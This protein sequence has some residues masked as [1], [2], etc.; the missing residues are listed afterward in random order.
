M[1][2]KKNNSGFTLIEVVAVIGVL[3]VTSA[4][5]IAN[6][7]LNELQLSLSKDSALIASTVSKAKSLALQNSAETAGYG[8]RFNPE[9]VG[10]DSFFIFKDNSNNGYTEDDEIL[11]NK[12]KLS[13]GIIFYSP[14]ADASSPIIKDLVFYSSDANVKIFNSSASAISAAGIVILQTS[15]A[16][17]PSFNTLK[18]TIT[19]QVSSKV[20]AYLSPTN[21]D[22]GSESVKQPDGSFVTKTNEGNTGNEENITVTYGDEIG[23]SGSFGLEGNPNCTPNC[24]G[25]CSGESNGCGSIC[26][27]PSGYSCS[28]QNICVYIGGPEGGC[29][30][31]ATCNDTDSSGH[32]CVACLGADTCQSINGAYK[33]APVCTPNCSGKCNGES[34]GCPSGG[35]CTCPA[36]YTC[37]QGVC[38]GSCAPTATCN[39]TVPGDPTQKCVVCSA[40][41]TCQPDGTCACIPNCSGKCNGEANG[42][43]GF[44]P[45]CP[46]D[47]TCSQ[48]VCVV[49]EPP[50][51]IESIDPPILNK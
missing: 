16:I 19:G 1:I 48:G 43:G 44:C 2:K 21:F 39:D 40:P 38:R 32:K 29:P 27:C 8:V 31:G 20:G 34:D 3:A 26:I 23:I 37:S 41:Q 9:G 45:T 35:I 33:C 50:L 49:T 14:S 22:L 36:D 7:R 13:S 15:S 18:I 10:N 47:Q 17:S 5:L 24:V 25:K 6:N 42:C 30:P 46:P 11:G 4:I 28:L 51:I 12:I